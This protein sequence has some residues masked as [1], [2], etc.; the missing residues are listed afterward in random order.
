MRDTKNPMAKSK[1]PGG[2]PTSYDPNFIKLI[3]GYLTRCTDKKLP[4]NRIEVKLP[5]VEG[6]ANF[7]GVSRST[8]FKWAEEHQEFSDS[9]EKIIIEQ[10]HRLLNNGLSGDYNATIAKLV[11]SANHGMRE[12]TDLELSGHDGGP[13]ETK[14]IQ[15]TFVDS[16][17]N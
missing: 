11:L 3:D 2:R 9:L 6:L 4:F 15:V 17:K 13:I 10:K 12:K 7:I 5:T 14:N 8:I 1:H 16:P